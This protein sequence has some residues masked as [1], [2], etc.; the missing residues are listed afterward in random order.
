MIPHL[1]EA[2]PVTD[3]TE[4]VTELRVLG[5]GEHWHH[6]RLLELIPGEDDDL[7]DVI[8]GQ[9]TLEEGLGGGDELDAELKEMIASRPKVIAPPNPS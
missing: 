4:E 1:H 2:L 9:E 8:L 3:I 7:L 6:L 5:W